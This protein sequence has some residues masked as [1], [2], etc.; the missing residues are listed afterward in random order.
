MI[1]TIGIF[2]NQTDAESSLRELCAFGIP[3]EDISYVYLSHSGLV[4]KKEIKKVKQ[5]IKVCDAVVVGSKFGFV[6][7]SGVLPDIG[8]F[9]VAGPLKA[10]FGI[11]TT[12]AV[13]G[14]V[15]GVV[16]G[17]F[18]GALM[19]FGISDGDSKRFQDYIKSGDI[20]VVVRLK[21]SEIKNILM[22]THAREVQEYAH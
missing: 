7:A 18:V 3:V 16:A 14:T 8:S 21:S 15:S 11:S 9:L 6:V 19:S 1:T 17:G 12:A 20:L 22:H 2:S 13:G 4:S 5:S 10:A